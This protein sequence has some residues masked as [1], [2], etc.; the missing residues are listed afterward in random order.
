MGGRSEMDLQVAQTALKIL[1]ADDDEG[2]RKQV[3]RALEQTGISCECTET[4]SIEEALEACDKEAFDCAIIDYWMPGGDGLHGIAV[5]HER[6]PSMSIIMSTG[7][8]DEMIATNAMRRGA[9]DYIPKK[10]ISAETIGRVIGRAVEKAALQRTIAEQ[11]EALENFGRVLVHDLRAPISVIVL[12]ADMIASKITDGDFEGITD[13]IGDVASTALRMGVLIDTLH[14]YTETDG[15]VEFTG[16]DMRRAIDDTLSNLGQTIEARHA[17]V[18]FGE[19]PWVTA[20][21]SLVGLLLQNLI[22]NGLKYCD[23][24]IPRVHVTA[25]PHDGGSWLFAV[26]DNGIGIAKEHCKAVFEP[27]KR[28]HPHGKYE[29]TGL[30]LA[31]CKKIVERHGGTIWCAPVQGGGTSFFFTL[32]GPPALCV[33]SSSSMSAA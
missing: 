25:V 23:S 14:A 27:F 8:G 16:V 18:T 2:D 22:G 32:P 5:L 21:A 17:Q 15:S 20:N 29:G 13:I 26:T 1:I 9:T 33:P 28:L 24:E 7:Q 12:F 4:A 19:L 31:T 10:L 30:G 11:R 3:M 6:F